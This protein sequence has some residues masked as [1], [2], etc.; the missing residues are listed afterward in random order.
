MSDFEKMGLHLRS[1]ESQYE[2]LRGRL[3]SGRGNILGRFD[4]IKNLGAKANKTIALEFENEE[5]Q[6]STEL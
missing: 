3:V 2:D 4:K 5:D 1:L 6:G